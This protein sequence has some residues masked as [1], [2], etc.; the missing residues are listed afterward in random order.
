MKPGVSGVFGV[1]NFSVKCLNF[2]DSDLIMWVDPTNLSYY[3]QIL[4]IHI[5]D[6]HFLLF[7]FLMLN[8]DLI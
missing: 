7:E 3:L 1:Q 6:N 4:R 8:V 5:P 2:F